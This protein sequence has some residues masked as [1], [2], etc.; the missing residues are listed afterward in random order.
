MVFA[1][2]D[3]NAEWLRPEEDDILLEWM[4]R[5]VQISKRQLLVLIIVAVSNDEISK[6]KTKASFI[7]QKST[8]RA[9][10]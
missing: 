10:F 3:V 6:D 9:R 1:P 2:G 5:F 8:S 4:D 7:F